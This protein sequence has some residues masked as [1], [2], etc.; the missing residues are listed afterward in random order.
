MTVDFEIKTKL[1]WRDSGECLPGGQSK[2]NL[3]TWIVWSGAIGG[4]AV[5]GLQTVSTLSQAL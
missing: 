2:A 1:S 4:K 5:N 3:T